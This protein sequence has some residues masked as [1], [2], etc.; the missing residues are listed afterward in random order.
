MWGPRRNNK[1]TYIHIYIYNVKLYIYIQT[2]AIPK[3][4][5]SPNNSGNQNLLRH[6]AADICWWES[7]ITGELH[8]SSSADDTSGHCS[9][10]VGARRGGKNMTWRWGKAVDS[11]KFSIKD[12]QKRLL[13]YCNTYVYMYMFLV[14]V[15]I[16]MFIWII[17]IYVCVCILLCVHIYV[18]T[19]VYT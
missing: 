8:N 1:T 11:V 12:L 17:Y 2:H 6:R 14:C 7:P 15:H 18:Y 9:G 5:Q 16:Y 3:Y 13:Y 19:Y 4:D 10:R